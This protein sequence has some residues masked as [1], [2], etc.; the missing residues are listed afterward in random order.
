MHPRTIMVV[1][2]S[3]WAAFYGA[4]FASDY[5][6]RT[7]SRHVGYV[8][9]AGRDVKTRP[10]DTEG[11]G[12]KILGS[13]S[14]ARGPGG[15]RAVQAAARDPRERP[16]PG[17]G[18]PS[19]WGGKL[20]PQKIRLGLPP[21]GRLCFQARFLRHQAPKKHKV[22][23]L[24]AKPRPDLASQQRKASAAAAWRPRQRDSP[25]DRAR[26]HPALRRQ[27][28]RLSRAAGGYRVRRWRAD[29]G[30]PAGPGPSA[31]VGVPRRSAFAADRR[32]ALIPS[33]TQ[34]VV[35]TLAYGAWHRSPCAVRGLGKICRLTHGPFHGLALGYAPP[36][37]KISSQLRRSGPLT[38]A[39]PPQTF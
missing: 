14:D 31:G 30:R 35:P 26:R 22:S 11:P 15:G 25:S 17:P 28:P 12:W 4:P 16:L 37:P 10:I 34:D 8:Q 36:T 2:A 27:P 7:R 18:P 21:L 9:W 13:H 38:L 1:F 20:W 6:A 3:I 39:P 23:C 32:G 19:Q 5:T 29:G 33:P 24:R